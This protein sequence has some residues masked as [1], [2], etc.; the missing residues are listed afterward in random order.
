MKLTVKIFGVEKLINAIGGNGEREFDFP[1][2]N[3]NRL[4]SEL[5]GR[6]GFQW[7]DFPLLK[8]WEQ[9]LSITI[10]HNGEI[11]SKDDYGRKELQEGDRVS[12]L[13]H[14]GCC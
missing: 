11:L 9:N 1:G 12:F 14:T 4:F 3:V 2:G 7:K 5:L 10:L 6:L 13:L 8:N